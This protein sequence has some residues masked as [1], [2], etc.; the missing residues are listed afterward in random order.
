MSQADLE[1]TKKDLQ[2]IFDNLD[3]EGVF[4]AL[5]TSC[6]WRGTL[7]G[8]P[9]GILSALH[10]EIVLQLLCKSDESNRRGF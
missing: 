3:K 7:A 4:A 2:D 6:R 9:G 10:W 1:L 8:E 5:S